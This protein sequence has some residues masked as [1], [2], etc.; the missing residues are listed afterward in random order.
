MKISGWRTVEPQ[1][2]LWV[3]HSATMAQPASLQFCG[4]PHRI[5]AGGGPYAQRNW[6]RR[7]VSVVSDTHSTLTDLV[8]RYPDDELV[9]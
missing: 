7:G 9:V 8:I 2:Q 6:H 4:V 3:S 1:W 5:A